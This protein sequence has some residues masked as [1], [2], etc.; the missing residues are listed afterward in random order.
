VVVKEREELGNV[1]GESTGW[2]ILDP[3]HMN[4]MGESDTYI[5]CGFKLEA[6]KLTVMNEVVR[7]HM[8]LDSIADGFFNVF[9]QCV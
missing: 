3:F 6:T 9:T 1:K 4:K 5:S 8:K 7:D 2:Q